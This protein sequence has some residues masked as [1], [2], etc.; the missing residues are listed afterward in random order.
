MTAE[1]KE[2]WEMRADKGFMHMLLMPC[3][4]LFRLVVLLL[5]PIRVAVRA[6]LSAPRR[7]AS[8]CLGSCKT[9]RVAVDIEQPTSIV[10]VGDEVPTAGEKGATIVTVCSEDA[11]NGEQPPCNDEKLLVM[12]N[13]PTVSGTPVEVQV[14]GPED[15][16]GTVN[17]EPDMQASTIP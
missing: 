12:Q 11:I 16:G 17:D 10:P 1:E 9:S 4:L 6:A 5:V 8:A 14:S 13:V 2:Y 15:T 3:R 7:C